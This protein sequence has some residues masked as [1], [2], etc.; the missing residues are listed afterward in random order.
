MLICKN[1]D[2]E[3][4]DGTIKCQQCNMEGNFI[5]I[6]PNGEKKE[7]IFVDKSPVHCKNCGC[8]APGNDIKCTECNFPLPTVPIVSTVPK[9]QKRNYNDFHPWEISN[10]KTG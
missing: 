6:G 3:N 4:T 2:S 7:A 10:Q 5:H 8:E 9:A 1:C